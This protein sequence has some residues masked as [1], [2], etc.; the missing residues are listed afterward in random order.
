MALFTL[1]LLA[2]CT[3]EPQVHA[4]EFLAMGTT[5]SISIAAPAPD[6]VDQTLRAI[7]AQVQ[8]LAREWYPWTPDGSGELARLNAAIATGR[9]MEV[10]PELVALLEEAMA[11]AQKSGGRFDPAIGA[12]VELWGFNTA[13]RDAT[14]ALPR[15][16]EIA[17]WT[18]SHP[19]YADLTVHGAAV[20]SS[21]PGLKLDL[22]AIAKGRAVDL[23]VNQ[24]K[25][26]GVAAA[27]VAAGGSVSVVGTA[28]GRPWRVAIRDPRGPGILGRVELRDGESID[29]SGDY[30]RFAVVSDRPIHHLLDPQTGVPADH[31]AS[32]TVIAANST[33][34]DAAATALFVAGPGHWQEVARALGI[35]AVLRIDRD[36]QLQATR[37]MADRLQ[38]EAAAAA[39]SRLT[40]VEL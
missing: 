40:V 29:T 14:R 13:P 30:E 32:V 22:G 15:P 34:A 35:D 31:T 21:N 18:A 5:V 24:L 12:L 36:G 37:R 19:T 38:W 16:A 3:P 26:G 8:H 28:A 10:S 23:A 9:T 17:A 27:L 39:A 11:L 2:G 4:L 20:S 6:D 1:T 7:E 33:L 25:A